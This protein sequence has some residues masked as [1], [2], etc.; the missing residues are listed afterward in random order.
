[1]KNNTI[2]LILN[3][4]TPKK[5]RGGYSHISNLKSIAVIAMMLLFLGVG[6]AWGD[7]KL[8]QS[9]YTGTIGSLGSKTVNVSVGTIGTNMYRIVFE[10]DFAMTGSDS[11]VFT[12]YDDNLKI[13]SATMTILNGGK[14]I[15]FDMPSTSAPYFKNNVMVKTSEGNYTLSGTAYGSIDWS[16]TTGECSALSGNDCTGWSTEASTG[17]A[18]SWGALLL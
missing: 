8:C 13:E 2:L 16:Q 4:K 17:G 3:P 12:S 6:N 14:C 7:S 15:Y 1:M 11:Y 5:S 9:S 18:V 10:S